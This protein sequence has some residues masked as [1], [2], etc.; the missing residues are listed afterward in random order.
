MGKIK[1]VYR[2]GVIVGNVKLVLD[3][4]G[5]CLTDCWILGIVKDRQGN[6]KF[7]LS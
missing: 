6:G 5:S 1:C 2:C 3:L 7:V 4:Y